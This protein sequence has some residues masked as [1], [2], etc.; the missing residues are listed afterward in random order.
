MRENF[1]IRGFW[2]LPENDNKKVP[3]ILKFVADKEVRLELM[4]SFYENAQQAFAN[5]QSQYFEIIL[6]DSEGTNLTLLRC[7]EKDKRVGSAGDS[8]YILSSFYCDYILKGDH[9]LSLDRVKFTRMAISFTYLEDWINPNPFELDSMNIIKYNPPPTHHIKIDKINSVISIGSSKIISNNFKKVSMSVDSFFR[10]LPISESKDL[11]WYEDVL[12]CLGNFL[13]LVVGRPIYPKT[14]TAYLS[15]YYEIEIYFALNNI[16]FE[17]NIHFSQMMIPYNDLKSYMDKFLNNW[18]NN[19]DML[20][21]VYELFFGTYYAQLYIPFYFLS[22]IQAIEAFHRRVYGDRG[23]Y[24]SESDYDP[25]RSSLTGSIPTAFPDGR[26]YPEGFRASLTNRI[27]Y[28]NEY[29]LRTRLKQLSDVWGSLD[30]LLYENKEKFNNYIVCTRNYLTHYEK[31]PDCRVFEGYQLA[32]INIIIH[33]LF[34]IVLLAHM[35]IP[36]LDAFRIVRKHNGRAL[37]SAIKEV[38]Q[39]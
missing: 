25:I 35:G 4:G 22:L 38:F 34:L 39:D 9:F 32:P 18:F 2:W 5:K 3:G 28:G 33:S 13:T 11:E 7:Q 24:L 14:I 15:K 12:G 19:T 17:A 20:E 37:T 27:K 21:P 31:S 16:S 6:G 8:E 30:P 23:K 10:I 29:S 26:G 1:E 36:K